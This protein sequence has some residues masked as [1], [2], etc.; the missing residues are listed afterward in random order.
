MGQQDIKYLKLKM[1]QYILNE[2]YES[3]E[4]LKQW[5]IEL[6]GN[7]ELE[8]QKEPKKSKNDRG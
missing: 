3:A 7:P 4:R 8:P 2:E 5:I 1:Q 6:G